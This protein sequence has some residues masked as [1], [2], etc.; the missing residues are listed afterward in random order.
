MQATCAYSLLYDS[1]LYLFF[2]SNDLR[3]TL[4]AIHQCGWLH[5]DLRAPNLAQDAIGYVSILDFDRAVPND[6]L[7]TT[8][9][10]EELQQVMVLLGRTIADDSGYGH[11]F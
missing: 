5:G 2:I 8:R 3:N 1:L 7:D 9:P 10:A 4:S 11:S 6:F